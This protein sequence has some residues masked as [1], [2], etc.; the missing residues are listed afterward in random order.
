MSMPKH[1]LTAHPNYLWSCK[2]V[3]HRTC[4]PSRRGLQG[5]EAVFTADSYGILTQNATEMKLTAPIGHL[6]A[7]GTSGKLQQDKTIATI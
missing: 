3:L 1:S 2:G 4:Y 5:I 7:A 6:V